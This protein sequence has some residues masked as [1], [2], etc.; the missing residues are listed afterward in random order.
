MD[1][2]EDIDIKDRSDD[3]EALLPATELIISEGEEDENTDLVRPQQRKHKFTAIIGREASQDELRELIHSDHHHVITSEE[4]DGLVSD[5]GSAE[6]HE[7]NVNSPIRV[8]VPEEP[9]NSETDDEITQLVLTPPVCTRAI[10][11][12]VT[13]VSGSRGPLTS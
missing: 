10:P 9:G 1:D 2:E 12:G 13:R 3:R 8:K 11:N 7:H 5:H 6:D 4:E